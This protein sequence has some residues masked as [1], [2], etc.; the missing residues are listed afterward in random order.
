VR[1]GATW[2]RLPGTN[3]PPGRLPWSR[4]AALRAP[5][6][7]CNSPTGSSTRWT[8]AQRL[9]TCGL[10]RSPMHG[11]TATSRRL[12]RTF[13]PSQCSRGPAPRSARV[14]TVGA[15]PANW[16]GR[17][18]SQGR[19]RFVAR[20][21]RMCSAAGSSSSCR[22][23]LPDLNGRCPRKCELLAKPVKGWS[24]SPRRLPEASPRSLQPSSR[25]MLSSAVDS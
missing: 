6:R 24:S 14:K 4:V 8:E 23:Q 17:G 21:F 11:S 7:L 12:R 22:S 18:I 10:A 9:S 2:T 13:C 25:G 5:P 16:H 20:P 19:A 3:A 15:R 1:R